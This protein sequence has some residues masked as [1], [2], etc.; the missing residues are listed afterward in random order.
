MKKTVRDNFFWHVG[1]FFIPNSK[2]T[3]WDF[4]QT[5]TLRGTRCRKK[6][7]VPS[8]DVSTKITKCLGV[9]GAAAEWPEALEK[10]TKGQKIPDKSS[11]VTSGR[12]K[13]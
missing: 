10:R 8:Q 3:C 4:F 2:H 1:L 12:P 5:R 11:A 13:T 9:R 6:N 7:P